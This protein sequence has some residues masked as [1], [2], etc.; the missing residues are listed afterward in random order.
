MRDP[1]EFSAPARRPRGPLPRTETPIVPADSIGGRALVAVVAIMTFL[2]A[3]TTGSVMMIRNAAVDW[4][5]EVSRE[6][7]I[8]VRPGSGDVEADVQKAAEI[9]RAFP[10]LSDARVYSREESARLLEP[11]LGSGLSM[12]DLPVP[13]VIVLRFAGGQPPD[14]S[15]LRRN[16]AAAVPAATLDDHRGWIERMRAMAN[17]AVVTGAVILLLV[18]AAMILSVTFATRG[19]MASNRPVVEVLHLVGARDGF[20]AAEFQRHFLVLGF[21]GG[22]LG[23]GAAMALFALAG[24]LG[25]WLAGTAAGDQ[26]AALFGS[27]SIGWEGYAALLIL[28]VVAAAVTAGT[29]RHTVNQT[30]ETV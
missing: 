3:M 14:L 4:Q 22:L 9:A 28:I 25:G 8:Q 24:L 26:L 6:V 23:G 1:I 30:L 21:K 15:G 7:T 2:A 27:F 18:L 13:R 16:L 17:A 19:A 10:G 11:W 20:I 12:E 5:S 29:S